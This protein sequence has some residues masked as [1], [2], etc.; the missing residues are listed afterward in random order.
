MTQITLTSE[1]AELL[2]DTNTTVY[3]RDPSGQLLGYITRPSVTDSGQPC[4]FTSEEI[5]AAI[6]AAE[7]SPTWRTLSEIWESLRR[8]HPET[9]V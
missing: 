3:V 8:D 1:Q 9:F 4:T 2:R 5:A 6:E 7:H